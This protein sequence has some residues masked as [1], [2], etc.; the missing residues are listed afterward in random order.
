MPRPY[1]EY[2]S[3]FGR[4]IDETSSEDSDQY[5]DIDGHYD[6]EDYPGYL[7]GDDDDE[8]DL[9]GTFV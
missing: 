8:F 1:K 7:D 4:H 2:Q 6:Y 5:L 9:Y 3:H